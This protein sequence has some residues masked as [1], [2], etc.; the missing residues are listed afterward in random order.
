MF[1]INWIIVLA[2]MVSQGRQAPREEER[3]V[4]AQAGI[5]PTPEQTRE[6]QA[7]ISHRLPCYI[8][9]IFISCYR[10]LSP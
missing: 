1:F 6:M 8:F 10:S 3:S 2:V 7:S 5:G 4:A 9:F